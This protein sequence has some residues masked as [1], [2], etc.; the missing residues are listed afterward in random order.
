MMYGLDRVVAC[1]HCS[2]LARQHTLL[3]GNTF[4]GQAWTDGKFGAPMLELSPAVVKCRHC[5]KCYWL[6]DAAK[7]G[8]M[9]PFLDREQNLEQQVDPAWIAAKSVQEPQ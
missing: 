3:S 2:G 1:P 7:V 8:H 9:R 4:G 6:D 5:P